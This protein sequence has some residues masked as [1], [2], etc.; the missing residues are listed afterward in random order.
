MRYSKNSNL[1]QSVFYKRI[2]FLTL[3][4]LKEDISKIP[5]ILKFI[6]SRSFSLIAINIWCGIYTALTL[7]FRQFFYFVVFEPLPGEIA[8]VCFSLC[9]ILQLIIGI[10]YAYYS[11]YHLR[12][13]K[14][15][16]FQYNNRIRE[17]FQKMRIKDDFHIIL[18]R[19]LQK[20]FKWLLD[21][22]KSFYNK[23]KKK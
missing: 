23:T 9:S 18:N 10:V 22:V 2:V 1:E 15:T 5:L 14:T 20:K 16:K 3:Y 19:I 6:F 4:F 13:L 17:D 12:N 7:N 11:P 8:F 21:N